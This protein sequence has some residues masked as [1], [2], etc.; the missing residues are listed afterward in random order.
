MPFFGVLEVDEYTPKG[1]SEQSE[2][3][4]NNPL[5]SQITQIQKASSETD[6]DCRALRLFR[7]AY[8]NL[9]NLR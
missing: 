7:F 6:R 2:G 5:I 1:K 4:V 9:C 3:G 8:L